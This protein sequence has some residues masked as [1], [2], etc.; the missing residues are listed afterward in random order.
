MPKSPPQGYERQSRDP[1]LVRKLPPRTAGSD[2]YPYLH[3]Q[4]AVNNLRPPAQQALGKNLLPDATR[5]SS[6]PL[7]GLATPAQPSGKGKR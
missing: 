3:S 6:S 2:F 1:N 5:G 7:G 4:G